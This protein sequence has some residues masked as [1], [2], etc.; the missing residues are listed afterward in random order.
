MVQVTRSN[1]GCLVSVFDFLQENCWVCLVVG[2]LFIFGNATRLAAGRPAATRL[3]PSTMNRLAIIPLVLVMLS[4]PL[5]AVDRSDAVRL[6]ENLY[7][8]FAWEAVTARPD[9]GEPGLIDQPKAGLEQFFTPELTGLILIDRKEAVRSGEVGRLDFLPLWNAQDPS[10]S[11]LSVLAGLKPNTVAVSFQSLG[12]EVKTEL[13]F[14]VEETPAGIRI[15]DI[16]YPSG[17]S[18]ASLLK[19]D[20]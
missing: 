15:A 4:A 2:A 12:A 8:Q 13:V 6:V 19:S 18:L 16:E 11:D 17:S 1:R 9:P 3:L 7:R 5:R 10:A 14:V 20:E